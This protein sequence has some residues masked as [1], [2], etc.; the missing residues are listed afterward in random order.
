MLQIDL[1]LNQDSVIITTCDFLFKHNTLSSGSFF[2]SDVA[3]VYQKFR[4]DCLR[5]TVD[6][7]EFGEFDDDDDELGEVGDDDEFE[8]DD[9]EFGEFGDDDEFGEF[10][11]EENMLIKLVFESISTKRAIKFQFQTNIDCLSYF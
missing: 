5:E 6:D 11:D 2:L 7:D 10:D 3:L 4:N 9:D 1:S 8:F